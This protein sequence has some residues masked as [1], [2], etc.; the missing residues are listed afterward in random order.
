MY[1]LLYERFFLYFEEKTT[2]LAARQL[3]K[4]SSYIICRC[5]SS[6][7]KPKYKSMSIIWIVM[8][9]L[10]KAPHR[11]MWLSV[12][13]DEAKDLVEWSR[14]S[15]IRLKKI[16]ENCWWYSRLIGRFGLK[17]RNISVFYPFT[18]YL[19]LDILLSWHWTGNVNWWLPNFSTED[20][21]SLPVEHQVWH[22][23]IL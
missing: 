15:W 20:Q 18:F 3:M 6:N 22:L 14:S 1:L 19:Y 4:L 23:N 12:H 11:N 13:W 2:Y 16:Q 17:S 7:P 9:D 21:H 10:K 5:L 8:E